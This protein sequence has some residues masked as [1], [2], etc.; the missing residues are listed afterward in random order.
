MGNEVAVVLLKVGQEL[1]DNNCDAVQAMIKT[2]GNIG[3][4]D[5]GYDLMDE[6][7]INS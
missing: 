2:V 1:G 4:F 6:R 3:L 5:I 7:G